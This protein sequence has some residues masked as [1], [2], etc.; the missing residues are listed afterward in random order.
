MNIFTIDTGKITAN[1]FAAIHWL[2]EF[3]LGFMPDPVGEIG[4]TRQRPVNTR[5][6]NFKAICLNYWIK[7]IEQIGDTVR[8]SSAIVNIELPCFRTLGHHL[9]GRL[10]AALRTVGKPRYAYQ[11]KAKR[12]RL[13][14]NQT[15]QFIQIRQ[16]QTFLFD[17]Q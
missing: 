17:M 8:K 6:A 11:G 1:I 14:R 15:A 4:K 3:N 13:G 7:F 16:N 2:A 10:V 5:R 12:F 9:Q